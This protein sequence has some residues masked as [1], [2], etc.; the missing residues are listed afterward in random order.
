MKNI[1]F[2]LSIVVVSLLMSCKTKKEF[3]PSAPP[4]QPFFIEQVGISY[5]SPP[6]V[7]LPIAKNIDE[8]EVSSQYFNIAVP[9]VIDLTG[10]ATEIKNLISDKFVTSLDQRKRFIVRDKNNLLNLARHNYEADIMPNSTKG[11]SK[12]QST[13]SFSSDQSTNQKGKPFNKKDST[14]SY[15]YDEPQKDNDQVY[16]DLETNPEFFEEYI[17]V[18]KQYTDGLLRIT[19]TGFA[20]KMLDIDY[21]ITSSLVDNKILSTGSGR[22]GFTMTGNPIVYRVD[23]D[24]IENIVNDIVSGFPNPDS[25]LRITEVIGKK[26][27]VNAGKN[28]NISEGM[29]GFV[30]KQKDKRTAYKAVF[31]VTNVF[32]E[33]F[34]AELIVEEWSK[35]IDKNVLKQDWEQYQYLLNEIKVGDSVK[36]K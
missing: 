5:T 32:S 14:A 6:P 15:S 12:I 33:S 8:I 18:I 27:T 22:I 29:V 34:R 10:A 4:F 35:L 36:M 31:K 30:V 2:I 21:K 24:D 13:T 9:Q 20:D 17:K 23:N 3:K 19:I 11:P 1:L 16:G 28:K 26:I 7:L 25:T